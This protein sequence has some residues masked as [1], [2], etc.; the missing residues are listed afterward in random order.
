MTLHLAQLG[1]MVKYELLMQWRRRS[2]IVTVLFLFTGLTVFSLTTMK[3]PLG[4]DGGDILYVDDTV[5][6]ATVTMRLYSTG[7]VT[8][9]PA[10]EAV[11]AVIP[12]WLRN[13]DLEQ[14]NATLKIAVMLTLVTQLLIILLL[15]MSTETIPLDRHYRVRELLNTL[16]LSRT[17]YLIGKLLP[18][19]L[20]LGAGLLL[21]MV[22]Y[23]PVAQS[24]FGAFDIPAYLRLW[25]VMLFPAASFASGLAVI[26]AS[27]V[28]TRRAS[29]LVGL[30]LI[31]AGVFVFALVIVA[32]FM[33][34]VGRANPAYNLLSYDG[35]IGSMTGSIAQT[36]LTAHAGLLVFG[37][38]TWG[39]MRMRE[40]KG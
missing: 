16:P 15:L 33:P 20:G 1:A 2:L 11:L 13:I 35:L 27:G 37:V 10:D 24:R 17:T 5:S 30:A 7:E 18:L 23:V 28:G 25:G 14:A 9:V 32:V 39:L 4:G 8:S 21:C 38:T 40:G 34:I 12:N 6:P 3:E 22:L 26:A 29:V 31:P 19:W 36:M